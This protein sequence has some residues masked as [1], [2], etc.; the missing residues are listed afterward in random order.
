MRSEPTRAASRRARHQ[1]RGTEPQGP[2]QATPARRQRRS[3]RDRRRQ[4]P[5]LRGAIAALV[6][7]AVTSPPA[8]GQ[9]PTTTTSPDGAVPGL[10]PSTTSTTNP[11]APP[12]SNPSQETP[13]APPEEPPAD[14]PSPPPDPPRPAQPA[15][16]LLG[17]L[18]QQAEV[19][20]RRTFDAAERARRA[21]AATLARSRTDVEQL[22]AEAATLAAQRATAAAAFRRSRDQLKRRAVARY[23]Y[24]AAAEVNQLLGAGNGA[25][26]TRRAEL[27]RAVLDADRRR[28]AA[29]RAAEEA[30]GGRL[31]KVLT[32]LETAQA[33]AIV[34]A[35]T[36]SDTE[37]EAEATRLRLLAVR[38]GGPLAAAGFAFPVAGPRSYA[39]TFGAPRMFGTPYAHSHQG[40]DIFAAYDTPVVAVER[41]VLSRVGTDVLGGNKLWLVGASGTR[42]YYAHLSRHAPSAADGVVVEAG[43]VIGY[44]GTSGNAAGTPP[45]THLQVHPDGGQAVN[46]YPL[47]RLVEDAVN[48]LRPNADRPPS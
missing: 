5:L 22:S 32:S 47:L 3:G 36:L 15:A 17:Q 28:V 48:R 42:Y 33:A 44:V 10:S 9:S 2:R 21:A 13:E 4:P 40:T 39:D 25:E 41:G 23:V 11:G 14:A 26:F 45:H 12:P 6:L 30:V 27:V 29:F 1:Q 35:T 19:D 37:I 38:A 8:A 16:A 34:A 46:P 43:E 18:A 7:L 20:A 24:G 31:A